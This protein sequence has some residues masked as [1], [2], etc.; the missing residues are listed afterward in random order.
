M[1]DQHY[2]VSTPHFDDNTSTRDGWLRMSQHGK[3]DALYSMGEFV[4]RRGFVSVYRQHDLTRLDAIA[5]GRM[6]IRTWQRYFGDRTI[7]RLCRAFLT[8]L[9]GEESAA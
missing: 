9:L 1:G 8:D 6:H 2:R 5:G 7:S 3:P 4:D